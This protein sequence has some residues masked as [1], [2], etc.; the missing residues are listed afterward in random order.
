MKRGSL[1]QKL[2]ITFTLILT[3][4]LVS[5]AWILSMWFRSFYFSDKKMQFERD[6]EYICKVIKEYNFEKNSLVIIK[7]IKK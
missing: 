7:I 3:I 1:L 4:V 6:G 2:I 5:L